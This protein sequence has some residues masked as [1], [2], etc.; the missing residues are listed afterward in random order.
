MANALD[1]SFAQSDERLFPS[2][3][4]LTLDHLKMLQTMTYTEEAGGPIAVC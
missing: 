3:S 4:I 1:H 2:F